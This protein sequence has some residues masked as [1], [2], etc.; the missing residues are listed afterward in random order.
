ML[1]AD[2]AG[3]RRGVVRRLVPER[4]ATIGANIEARQPA[5]QAHR[6]ES[7]VAERE[8]AIPAA[9]DLSHREQDEP[10]HRLGRLMLRKNEFDGF[11]DEREAGRELVV[12]L[13][14][15]EGLEQLGLLDAN[16]VARFAFDIPELHVRKQL[17][18]RA[19]AVLDAARASG[20]SPHATRSAAQKTDQAIGLAQREGLEDNGFR[21]AGR[22]EVSARSLGKRD[23]ESLWASGTHMQD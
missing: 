1:F 21:F 20:Y 15:V 8:D 7:E 17:Q 3:M 10:E 19:V 9:F 12:A 4:L 2:Q 16:Q 6:P 22:H 5:R 18:G 13:R 11:A 14:L 23:T